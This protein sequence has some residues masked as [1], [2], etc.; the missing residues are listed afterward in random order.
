VA[1]VDEQ[2]R[3]VERVVPKSEYRRSFALYLFDN[4]SNEPANDWLGAAVPL[5]LEADLLQNQFLTIRSAFD[6]AMFDK[7][8]RAGFKSWADAPWSIKREFAVKSNLDYLVTGAVSIESGDYVITKVVHDASTGQL[9]AKKDYRGRDLFALADSMAVDLWG[10]L[11]VPRADPKSVKDLPVAEITTSS[12][13]ALKDMALGAKTAVFD[14][15][16]PGAIGL[17]EDAVRADSTAAL[18]YFSLL[19]LYLDANQGEKIDT[20]LE[21]LMRHIYKLPE[22]DQFMGKYAYYVLHKEPEKSFAVLRMMIDLYP[23][24][25][26]PRETLAVQLSARNELD[27]AIEL[28]TDILKIDPERTEFLQ[29]IG[30]IYRHKGDFTKALEYYEAY[31]RKHPTNVDSFTE[32][33]A[34]YSAQGDYDRAMQNYDKALLLEPENVSAMRAEATIDSRLGRWDEA[35]KKYR[36]ALSLSRSPQER[37]EIHAAMQTHFLSRGELERS[38]DEMR[39][40][41]AEFEKTGALVQAMIVK[42]I[43]ARKLIE[44]GRKA[45]AFGI[46]ESVRKTMQPPYD[47]IVPVGYVFAYLELEEADS[48]EAALAKLMPFIEAYKIEQLRTGVYYAR[49]RIAEIRGDFRGA[50]QNYEQ[51]LA[52]DPTDA[53]IFRY[54]GRCQR[55]LRE[56][57]KAE[58][59]FSKALKIFPNDGETL[60]DYALLQTDMGAR[61]K[62]VETLKKALS[63]W[64]NADPVYKPA[65]DARETLAK[66]TAGSS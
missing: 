56:Y 45:E 11:K 17:L 34:V 6:A 60:Y 3:T 40:K 59:S 50:V 25:I 52:M 64:E 23:D 41:W 39:M 58:E 20:A 51:Q 35:L 18:A 33:A 9:V 36:N 53:S 22:R 28:Y 62:A 32:I 66:W 27:E 65:G 46:I 38:F 49:G 54:I 26:I 5:L 4:K 2:G 37:V 57:Q 29:S 31:A 7:L 13:Q 47:G 16:L 10:D 1:V 42:M 55:K 43:D 63:V 44:A 24:D 30:A 61:D 19:Q 48:A 15:D 8:Q 14:R 12:V 21:G